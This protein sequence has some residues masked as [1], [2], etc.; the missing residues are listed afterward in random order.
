MKR[1][2]ALQPLSREH[3]GALVLALACTRAANSGSAEKIHAACE[4]VARQFNTDLEPHFHQEEE[5]LL[6]LLRD[7]GQDELVRRTLDDHARL[8]AMAKALC[9]RD[10]LCLGEFGKTLSDHV[11]FEE[12]ELFPTTEQVVPNELL[13]AALGA[14]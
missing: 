8:R 5:A 7:A 9:G 6:P 14:D 4:R 12:Q 2:S 3:H 13:M 11:R 1:H 10:T